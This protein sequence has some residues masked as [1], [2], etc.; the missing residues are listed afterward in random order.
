[1][2][3]LQDI[4]ISYGRAD[5]KQFAK[6]LN[7]RLVQRG[8]TVWFDFE[9]IPQGVDYQKQIDQ[10][11]QKA[12]NFVF[13]ISPHATNSPYC[14]REVEQAIALNKRL[15]PIMHVQEISR[16]TWQQQEPNGSD[17]DWEAYTTAGKHS[18]FTNL[19]PELAK[20]N[21]NQVSFKE[22]VDDFE[23]SFQALIEIFERQ[24]DYVR[25]HTVLLNKAF[26][27]EQNQK[28]TRYLLIGEE[29]QQA[30]SWLKTQ[31]KVGQPPCLPTDLHCEFITE[32]I[33]NANNLMTQV[34]LAHA[35]EDGSITQQLRHSLMRA[36]IT[37][38][39][40]YNDIE[41]ATNFQTA[42]VRGVEEADNVV[43]VLSPYSLE[44]AY[45]QQEIDLALA[46]NK[47]LIVMTAGE[48][49]DEQVPVTIRHLQ[50]IDLTDNLDE[51]D[52]QK[53]ESDLLRILKRDAVYYNEHKVLLAKARKWER[54]QRNPCILLRGYE[55][56]HAQAWL[57]L[58]QQYPNHGP[59]ALQSEFI[60]ES[61]RQPS[62]MSLD[63]FVSY[64][65]TDS[66]FARR[67]NDA[68]QRQG[69]R[70]WFDQESIASGADFQ[71][72]IYRGIESSDHFLFILS[73]RSVKS[74]YCANEVEYAASLNKR[75]VTVLH[76]T[77]D[78]ADLPPELAKVQW[79]DFQ[80]NNRD[81][82]AN[83]QGLIL[84]LDTDP[85]H[86]RF[87][88]QLLMQAIAWNDRG[89]RESLL[90]RGD[91]LVEAEQWLVKASNKQPNPTVLQG[92]YIAASRTSS[93]S[94]QRALI[95]G[96]GLLLGIAVIGG[97]IGFWQSAVAR[98]ALEA[99]AE[100]RALAEERF[101]VATDAEQLAERRR[102][103]AETAR[104]DADE[105]R[106]AAEQ[107]QVEAEAQ[108]LAAEEAKQATEQA[109]L[110]AEAAQAAEAAQRDFAEQKRQE[111]ET[112]QRQAEA[113]ETK[114]I[115]QT[116][117]ADQEALNADV[118]AEALTVENLMATNLNTKA[119]RT[120]LS[121]A[122]RIKELSLNPE[123]LLE[124]PTRLQAISVLREIY[125]LDGFLLRN[126][127]AGHSRKVLGVSF[128]PDGETLVTG[129]SD[130]N[131]ILWDRSGQ[132]L[133]V[134][135]GHGN[136]VGGVAFSPDGETIVSGSDDGTV[137]LW[138]SGGQL[139]DTLE[140]HNDLVLDVSF[141]PDSQ[142]IVSADARG[143][144]KLW[145]RS[146]GEELA[147]F[148]GHKQPV[149]SV[150]FSNDGTIIATASDDNTVKLWTLD[151]QELQA[152]I[153]HDDGVRSAKFSPDDTVIATTSDDQSV[154]LW[155]LEGQEL[156]TLTGHAGP[157]SDISF[158]PD[159]KE[160]ATVST[161]NTVKIWNRSGRELQTLT[162]HRRRITSVEFS[163]G[164]DAIATTSYDKTTKLWDR[165]GR[166]PQ[167]LDGHTNEI[168]SVR[169]SP[170]GQAIATASDDGT[171]KLWAINGGERQ[172]LD[173]QGNRVKS[174]SFSPDGQ[175]IATAG[176]GGNFKLWDL[177]GQLLYT[178]A[179]QADRIFS[180]SFSPDGQIIATGSRD[181][182]TK[183]WD[184][185]GNEIGVLDNREDPIRSVNFSPDGEIIATASEDGIVKLWNRSGAEI[186]SLDSHED[187]VRSISFSPDG[188]L[189][190]TASHD[191][192]VKLWTRSGQELGTLFGHT[193]WVLSVSFSP[194]G[195]TIASG[196]SDGT[197]K[198]WNLQGQ[199]LQTLETG[200]QYARSVVF[201]PNA[202]MLASGDG[203]EVP[204]ENRY[205]GK[206]ILWNFNLNDLIAQSCIWFGDYMA[207]PTT[208]SDEKDLCADELNLPIGSDVPKPL[209]RVQNFFRAI[210]SPS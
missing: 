113:N 127:L 99:E 68:L 9:A 162:G 126:N 195:Q 87:H 98:R 45:C 156:L 163:P 142:T 16:E 181:G 86:L 194:D 37:T 172:T 40:H 58:A 123:D 65:R 131:V 85:E 19:H 205:R 144:V 158:S 4:F 41:F 57:K 108:R 201:S 132:Q 133:N 207:N 160:L 128:S 67:L 176:D 137:K 77:V 3:L 88:T 14:R 151:G 139:L 203:G 22:G 192:T 32:S 179:A 153:G 72:E 115:E 134:L 91:D 119:L 70:T 110:Q 1:M 145:A 15:V 53:D 30:E 97:G 159:G 25:H 38:W 51:A 31:F 103:T 26:E 140:G 50:R 118:R 42:M 166:K 184:L 107:A 189:I 155:T 95:G 93:M 106:M 165:S 143:T 117:R 5:S 66:D 170:D 164:G 10:G 198:L 34:F 208:P 83:F 116:Q 7:D 18:C 84:T 56:Q 173:N 48:V 6:Y 60:A 64:S 82:A 47:R 102:L 100:A 125:Q 104:E 74:P 157:V 20:I 81:F 61:E 130:N 21:W 154:K 186:G 54:Q 206:V 62:G 28:Q 12:D 114:A 71:Q 191:H 185:S 55:L 150:Q 8:Y 105:Q 135:S 182:T 141:S 44:S 63:V 111:A 109:L 199:E 174:I 69:K 96:L 33:K 73:P 75:I 90:L 193:N 209:T 149:R 180:I 59:I 178:F 13:I 197:V 190:A 17:A 79:I 177:R 200:E 210:L 129:G 124:G 148:K 121:L 101:Q 78:I 147:T 138:S 175:T 169:F 24:K 80:G 94:R 122:Q 183:L 112:A 168:T 188:S 167:I 152:L 146:S 2:D 204:G 29:R 161:D 23:R 76:R 202:L 120:A 89:H 27:W 196:S 49:A 46:L 35:E 11:I 92:D 43:L 39:I 36:G 171:V 52:Y 136:N 187:A